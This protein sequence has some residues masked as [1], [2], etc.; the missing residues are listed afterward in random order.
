VLKDLLLTTPMI[1]L[2]PRHLFA[3]E[4]KLGELVTL[5]N[6]LDPLSARG[7][8]V[9]RRNAGRSPQ[10]DAFIDEVSATYQALLTPA[11]QRA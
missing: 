1:G 3:A 5:E 10:L 8:I 7:G 6:E 11:T 9:R 2:A 4:T